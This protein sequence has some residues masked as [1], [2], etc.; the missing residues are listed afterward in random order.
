MARHGRER[1]AAEIISPLIRR[2]ATLTTFI[3][4]LV[5]SGI[6][7]SSTGAYLLKAAEVRAP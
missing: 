4:G 1:E 7:E 5:A 3:N 2:E 6:I